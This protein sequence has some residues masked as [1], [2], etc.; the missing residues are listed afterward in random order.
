MKKPIKKLIKI[1]ITILIIAAAIAALLLAVQAIFL[2]GTPSDEIWQ[3]TDAFDAASVSQL[4][5]ADG[6]DF[7]ILLLADIQ[8]G[9]SIKKDN[10]ALQM[11]DELIEE[12]DPDFIMTT[13]DNSYFL[14]ADILTKRAISHLS[15]YGIPWSTTLG[16]HDTD[17]LASRDWVGNQYENAENSLFQMGPDNVS[18]VGN[19]VINVVDTDGSVI[20][21]LIVL[22]SNTERKYE[23]GKDYDYIHEDQIAWYEWAVNG[24]S[25][26]PSMLFFHIPLPEFADAQAM[27]ESGELTDPTA[28]GENHETVCAP[29]Y[30]SGLFDKIAELGSTTHIFVGHDHINSLSVTYDGVRLTYG[31]KTGPTCYF[32][33]EMQGATLITITGDTNEVLVENIYK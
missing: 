7:T 6:E 11:M 17:S 13:G 9:A 29:P 22:D 20:Y 27:L 30:N 32:E 2:K 24:Q 19:Y 28:F 4:V 5:K 10:A 1:I 26:V 18:G 23:D 33:E 12:T 8:L 3:S 14:F 16:N 15:S 31:L 21:S 25:G